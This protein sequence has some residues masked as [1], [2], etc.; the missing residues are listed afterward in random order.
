MG[1]TGNRADDDGSGPPGLGDGP[2]LAGAGMPAGIGNAY[3]FSVLN[4]LSFQM[5]LGGPMVLYAKSLGA[6][7][8][9]LGLVAGLMPIMTV[10]QLPAARFIPR[11]GYKRFVLGGWTT[12]VL[13]IVGM[14]LVPGATWLNE[15]SRLALV[16]A[17]LFA[18][19]LSRG[20][21]S[22]A[23]L[24]WITNWVPAGVRGR[25]LGIDQVCVNGAS[26]LAFV[27]AAMVLGDAAGP[28]R[29][30]LVFAFSAAAG[31]G[32]LMFLRR[33]PDV[34]VPSE[35]DGGRGPVPWGALA[36]HPPFR[37][38]LEFNAAWSLAYGGL[39]TFIVSYL[40]TSGGMG[41]R[42]VLLVMSLSFVGGLAS[43][44]VAAGRMDRLGSKPVLGL[45]MVLGGAATLGWMLVAGGMGGGTGWA[46]ALALG[47][48]LC[49]ALFAVANN[50]LAMAIVPAMGRNHF[51]A[52][53]AVVWQLTLGI[54]PVLWGV[55]LDAVG[56]W[57]GAWAGVEWNRYSLFFGLSCM[58]FAWAFHLARRLEEP[59]AGAADALIRELLV[60]HPQRWLVRLF[61][62]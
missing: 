9:V 54:S 4:A 49:N 55:L 26:A 53:F 35:D 42:T 6:S 24:P 19:N 41:E 57:R 46:A 47:V 58:A 22:C 34:P 20:I 11:V 51:F 40:R 60:Q 13:F 3:G 21:S 2:A 23:W 31:F 45:T 44:G 8:T 17:L 28:G 10:A 7:A 43:Y 52:L 27:L 32:S 5:V 18:F 59:R 25:F 38:L 14:A 37:R 39:A 12:R 30:A 56:G 29:F 62:R 48:G 61:G 36:A 15:G 16:M 50:R 33:M 1:A